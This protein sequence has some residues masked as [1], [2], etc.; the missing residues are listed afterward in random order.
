MSV[1][2]PKQWRNWCEAA[3]LKPE[4]SGQR[5]SRWF[6]LVG[7]GRR[8]RVNMHGEFEVGAKIAD[9]DRWALSHRVSWRMPKS[10]WDFVDA[11]YLLTHTANAIEKRKENED[12]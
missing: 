11:V 9:F 7:K 3:G 2:L 1:K 4:S 5:Q 8:W 6:Y 10:K 12:V